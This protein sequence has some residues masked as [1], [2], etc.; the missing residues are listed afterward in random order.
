MGVGW[1]GR[2]RCEGVGWLGLGRRAA[3]ENGP[4]LVRAREGGKGANTEGP[5][6]QRGPPVA[7]LRA[8]SRGFD[9][10]I[11]GAAESRVIAESI[12]RLC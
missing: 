4:G 10:A 6:L 5:I 11:V 12:Q 8:P 1:V 3:A 2:V 9:S 7:A